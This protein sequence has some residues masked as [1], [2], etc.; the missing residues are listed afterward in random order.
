MANV[1][2]EKEKGNSEVATKGVEQLPLFLQG[3]E[4]GVLGR[5]NVESGDLVIPRLEIVQ[6]LSPC[7]KKSDPSYIE[8][9]EEGMM[10]NNV[11][12]ELYGHEVILIPVYFRK[13]YVIWK[14]RKKGGGF[15]GAFN[16]QPE[17]EAARDSMDDYADLEVLDTAHQFCLLV[18]P[19]GRVEEIVVS[20]SKSKMKVSRK[21]N[22]LIRMT[23]LDSFARSYKMATFEDTNNNNENYWN[24]TV[25]PGTFVTEEQY[26]SAYELYQVVAK[27]GARVDRSDTDGATNTE[28]APF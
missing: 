21:W 14:D 25:S 7:R 3:Q 11:T 17:A 12:R 15:R 23:N 22:S 2:S 24:F 6:A 19:D 4:G 18:K 28:G 5:E 13:E 10:F 9:A 8:G 27:S 1:K 16:S 20:M 26:R